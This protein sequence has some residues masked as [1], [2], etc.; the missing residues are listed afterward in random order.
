MDTELTTQ[1]ADQLNV[2]W[3]TRLRPWLDGLTDDEYFW[4]PV[5]ECCTVHPDGSIGFAFP[6]PQ[7]EPFTT[8][9]WMA[10]VIVGVLAMRNHFHFGGPPADY[11]SWM[12]ATD[13][14]TAVVHNSA[15][16][17]HAGST[18]YA[19]LTRRRWPARAALQRAR[20]PT[21]RC[22]RSSCTSTGRSS[23][24][25][26][27]SLVCVT[28]TPTHTRRTPM[29][30][31]ASP[32][33]DERG[34]LREFVAYHQSA[35]FA[36]AYG[37]TDEQARSTPSARALSIG[38]VIKTRD[39]RTAGMDAAGR[40]GTGRAVVPEGREAVVRALGDPSPDERAGAP[41]RA[42]RHYSRIHR[43]RNNVRAG[44][45]LRGMAGDGLAQALET[46]DLTVS[47]R[48]AGG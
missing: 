14:A 15:R 32:V 36:I 20:T 48:A 24:T 41:L 46:R 12:Y 19:V 8:I 35:Y 4:E 30:A 37:L 28:F 45:R 33:A 44:V 16:P 29:S 18:A 34:A 40:C 1:P 42:G 13:A 39:R 27:K 7:P 11:Q 47:V 31:L 9:A 38:G 17:T 43:R 3:R 5:K 25:T 26:P 23:I 21:T 10:H 22:P 6:P 2:H